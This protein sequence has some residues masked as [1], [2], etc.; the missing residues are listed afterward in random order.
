[1]ARLLFCHSC[2]RGDDRLPHLLQHPTKTLSVLGTFDCFYIRTQ[3]LHPVV[4]QSPVPG[5]HHGKRQPCLS[6]KP[7]KQSVRSLLFNNSA[8]RLR[9][10][11]FKVDGIGQLFVR[12]NGSRIG[13]DQ[14]SLN[15][16]LLQDATGLGAGIIKL[17]RLPDHNR[18]RAD[19]EN[20]PNI[21]IP[22]HEYPPINNYAL[23]IHFSQIKS[24]LFSFLFN[25]CIYY[26]LSAFQ[27]VI[28]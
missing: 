11:R 14:N 1:M 8:K 18:S 19:N 10:Q 13:I 6:A 25:T 2:G 21:L 7:G 16:L 28:S 15:P 17:R 12:H 9:R 20:L 5:E 23:S 3:K 22:G 27:R 24:R 26:S 4:L